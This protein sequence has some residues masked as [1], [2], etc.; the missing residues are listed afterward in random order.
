MAPKAEDEVYKVLVL[1]K[2]TK[3]VLAPLL[4]VND[5]RKHGITLHLVSSGPIIS[6]AAAPAWKCMSCRCCHSQ[7]RR[8]ILYSLARRLGTRW[9]ARQVDPWVMSGSGVFM[10][11]VNI[12]AAP[13]ACSCAG[14]SQASQI[15]Y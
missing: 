10:P 7:M 15:G 11:R 6:V 2:Y 4:R 12:E 14:V 8:S 13:T 9:S 1:D 5:L 3:D